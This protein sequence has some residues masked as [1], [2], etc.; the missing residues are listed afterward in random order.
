[1]NLLETLTQSV[2]NAGPKAQA[3]FNDAE[4]K[5]QMLESSGSSRA[6]VIRQ[7]LADAISKGQNPSGL[8]KGLDKIYYSS[9]SRA[10]KESASTGPAPKDSK[11]VA[12]EEALAQIENALNMGDERGIKLSDQEIKSAASFIEKGDLKGASKVAGKLTQ[13]IEEAIKLQ[14]EEE[15]ETRTTQDGTQ[16]SVGKKTGTIY[17]GGVPVSRGMQNTDSFNL[18]TG[19]K[20]VSTTPFIGQIE[21]VFP[22]KTTKSVSQLET[23]QPQPELYSQQ[24]KPESDTGV[25]KTTQYIVNARELYKQG[26]VQGALDIL[27][28]TDLPSVYGP[29]DASVLPDI[30]GVQPKQPAPTATQQAPQ[31]NKTSKGNQFQILS[32]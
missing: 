18:F 24:T 10:E 13:R 1:M 8:I 5:L 15:K 28:A 2:P 6:V 30:L 25:P 26:N 29:L 11:G 3:L 7:Q 23:V 14:N 22:E 4:Q 17:S 9:L 27:N 19:S 21:E 16:F 31:P 20:A 32:D 12:P